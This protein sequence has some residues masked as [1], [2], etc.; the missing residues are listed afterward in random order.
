MML[1]IKSIIRWEQLNKK[2]F[3]SLNYSDENDINSLLYV[4]SP[5]TCTFNEF[6]DNLEVEAAKAMIREFEKTTEI[7]SQFQI[8]EE[9]KQNAESE[10]SPSKPVY[11]KDVISTLVLSGLDVNYALYE[12]ELCDIPLFIEALENKTKEHLESERLWTYLSILPHLTNKMKSPRD[13]YAF[14]WE[15]EQIK[16]D[17]ALNIEQNKGLL[18]KFL[19]G[20]IID[21]NQIHWNK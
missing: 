1:T 5:I 9:K 8:K 14:P 19:K 3:S 13:L 12:M 4:C 10:L 15:I 6:L 21:I 11:I 18:D 16:A 7:L 2:P 17:A 20:E